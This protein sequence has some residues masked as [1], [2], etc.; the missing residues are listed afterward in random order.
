MKNYL[1]LLQKKKK[2]DKLCKVKYCTIVAKKKIIIQKIFNYKILKFKSKADFR[3]N[4]NK[5]TKIKLKKDIKV[6]I[7]HYCTN[8]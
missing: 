6:I 7:V 1:K 2:F 5:K 3:Q 8:K 4:T